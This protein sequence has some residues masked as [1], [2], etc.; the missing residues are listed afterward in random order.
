MK[1]EFRMGGVFM[2]NKCH[3]L[4]SAPFVFSSFEAPSILSQVI[5]FEFEKS[6]NHVDADFSLR[7]NVQPVE[8]VYDEVSVTLCGLEQR[9]DSRGDNA[10]HSS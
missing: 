8:I 4:A 2:C 6:P 1:S 3:C 10:C 9:A 7:L 5:S